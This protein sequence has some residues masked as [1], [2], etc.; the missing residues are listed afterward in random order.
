MAKNQGTS[1]PH[2]LSAEGR[3]LR[4]GKALNITELEIDPQVIYEFKMPSKPEGVAMIPREQRAW[5]EVQKKIREIR[6]CKTEESPYVDEQSEDARPERLPITFNNGSL[7]IN[8][9]N[10]AAIRYLLASD[11]IK[12]KSKILP[13]NASVR[14]KYYLVDKSAITKSKLKYED[15]EFEAKTIIKNADIED[16]RTYIRSAFRQHFADNDELLLFASQKAGDHSEGF[17]KDFNNPLHK[18]KAQVQVLFERGILTDT[19]GVVSLKETGGMVLT[20]NQTQKDGTVMRADEALAKWILAG[21]E[22]SKSFKAILDEK[23]K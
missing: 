11:Q 17:I 2:P 20:Y 19:K 3:A 16:L 23:S 10:A 14:D 4:E 8:G 7:R 22:D 15:D 9:S 21:S 18:L 12:G 13:Q 5:C 1:K 6:Y